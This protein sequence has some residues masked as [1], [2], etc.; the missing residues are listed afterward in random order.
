MGC[1]E[2]PF[3]NYFKMWGYGLRISE[4][5]NLRKSN[6]NSSDIIIIGKGVSKG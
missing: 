3:D 6:L 2:K 4:V 1:F 5:L